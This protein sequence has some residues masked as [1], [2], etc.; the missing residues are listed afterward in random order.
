M[1]ELAARLA[2]L[3]AQEILA[4]LV[5][6]VLVVLAGTLV[7]QGAQEALGIL[8]LLET[9]AL[10]AR[11]AIAEAAAMEAVYRLAMRQMALSVTQAVLMGTPLGMET[12]VTADKGFL[13]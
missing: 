1:G 11:E 8:A 5:Q 12:T 3:A 9:E 4:L 2:T 6:A 7:I 13:K 10:E